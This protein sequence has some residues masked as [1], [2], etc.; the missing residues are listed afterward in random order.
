MCIILVGSVTQKMH[1]QALLENGDGF[2]VYSEKLGLI[3]S[4]TP[5]QVRMAL[6]DFAIWHYRIGTSGDKSDNNIHPFPI[7]NSKFYLYHNGVLGNGLG[8][9]SD[10]H[11]LADMLQNVD[12]SVANSVIQSVANRNRFLIVSARSPKDFRV[13]GE[14][15]ADEGILMS[16]K[17]YKPVKSVYASSLNKY[18][19]TNSGIT[20]YYDELDKKNKAKKDN[21]KIKK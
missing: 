18:P 7:C 8:D 14:W 19:Y 9:K 10:T 11:A 16:H 2:S 12:I 13:F 6:N 1:E 15:E 20:D 5:A 21:L 3:K 4:P 17:M